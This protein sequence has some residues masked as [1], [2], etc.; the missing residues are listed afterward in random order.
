LIGALV[1]FVNVSLIEAVEPEEAASVIPG[2]AA[3]DQA[4]VGE[5]WVAEVAVYEKVAPLQIAAGVSVD[6]KAGVGFTVTVTVNVAPTQLP[7]APDV[8]VTVYTTSIGA[9]VEFVS[10][11]LIE[12]ALV[13]DASPVIPGIAD[14]ADQVYVVFE[15]T[16]SV[17][18]E[19]V[20]VKVPTLHIETD[21]AAITGVGL[22]TTTTLLVAEHPFAVT[23]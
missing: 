20:T 22:T 1:V 3:R 12:E 19:G 23:V 8:G 16:I 10:D 18:F 21:F 9:F 6:V 14:G 17:L 11:P 2:T 15:G 5:T 13:P 4:N 7:L